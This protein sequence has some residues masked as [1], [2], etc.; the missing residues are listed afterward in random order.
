MKLLL[1]THIL[2][3]AI[4]AQ[5]ALTPKMVYYL[6]QE[7]NILY[8]SLASVWEVSIKH[9]LHPD[10]LPVSAQDLVRVV[11]HYDYYPLRIEAEHIFAL[12]GLRQGDIVPMH[13]DPFDRMLIAQAKAEG[14]RLLTH[15]KRLSA[16]NEPCVLL[17]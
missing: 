5:P 7:E 9:N 16:Y 17:V 3:W 10:R 8:Y 1:D 6:E 4:S 12:D 13:K 14:M 11:E 15:D 2:L